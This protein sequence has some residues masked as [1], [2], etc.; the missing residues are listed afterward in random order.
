MK[1][2]R[3]PTEQS[4]SRI[5]NQARDTKDWKAAAEGYRS[6]LSAD[7]S[8]NPIWVQYGNMLKEAGELAR[9]E[10]AYRIALEDAPAIADTYVQL[11]H[12]L[13]LLGRSGEMTHAYLQALSIDPSSGPA[14]EELDRLG[15]RHDSRIPAGTSRLRQRSGVFARRRHGPITL[16]DRAMF[17]QCWEQALIH[18]RAVL[19]RKPGL[20][21]ILV[22]Y[23]HA[24]KELGRLTE[25]ASAYASAAVADTQDPDASL[26]LGHVLLRLDRQQEAETAY[27]A[28]LAIAPSLAGQLHQVG[29]CGT[30]DAKAL[31][32]EPLPVDEQGGRDAGVPDLKAE[33]GEEWSGRFDPDWY[34]AR[35]P[36][37]AA[38]GIDPLD[39]FLKHGKQEGR[40]PNAEKQTEAWLGRFDADWYLTHYS[41]IAAAKIDPL[42]HFL[43]HGWQEGRALNKKEYEEAEAIRFDADWY[44][45]HYTDLA[46]MGID[47]LT[48][49]LCY[50][51]Q[52]GR[53]PNDKRYWES[54]SE[55]L[56]A[57]WY[58]ERNQDVAR[59]Q[60]DAL[61]HYSNFGIHER[62]R[63]NPDSPLQGVPVTDARLECLKAPRLP[64][65]EVALLVSHSPTGR[66]KPHVQH[67][68]KSFK[69]QGVAIILIVMTDKPFIDRNPGLLD[70]VD[71]L[72]VRDNQGY[73]FAAWA[74]ILRICPALFDSSILYLVND[75]VFG[76]TN[77]ATFREMLDRLRDNPAD[78]IGLTEDI[79]KNRH[80]QS[81]FLACKTAVLSNTV[82]REFIYRIVSLQHKN[83]VFNEY[84]TCLT[85]IIR[86]ALLRCDALFPFFNAENPTLHCWKELV[87]QG[88]PFVKVS[89]LHGPSPGVSKS[90]WR[91]I[92]GGRGYDVS[93]ADGTLAE[94]AASTS[95]P[96]RT[97][98][99]AKKNFRQ[100]ALAELHTFL[101]S[102]EVI[103]LPSAN[104]PTVT[105]L[106]V[107]YNE[108]ELTLRC[109]KSIVD[110]VDVPTEVIIVDNASSD[111]TGYLFDRLEGARIFRNLEDL[112]F[113]RAANQGAARARGR[114]LLLINND[115][116][117]T[118]GALQYGLETLDSADDIGAVG[119]KL[120]LPDGTLQEAGSIIWNDA[121]CL[122]YGRGCDPKIAAFQFRRE[123]DYCSG[124]YML[125]RRDV[126]E[127][128]GRFDAVFA[129]A[130]YEET[131]LCMRIRDA[132]YR[133][134][135]D[136]RIE[137]LHY[138]FASAAS[139]TEAS[140]LMTRNR[141]L[142]TRRNAASL[143]KRHLASSA[144]VIVARLADRW[145]PRI[146]MI[147]NMMPFTHLG[148]GFPRAD[149]I[150]RAVVEAGFFVTYYPTHQT[151]ADWAEVHANFPIDV[152]FVLGANRLPLDQFLA[153]RIGYYTAMVVC[154]PNNMEFIARDIIQHPERY[155]ETAIAYDAEALVTPREVMRLILAGTPM[156]DLAKEAALKTE[157][158]LTQ[159][160]D[161]V[162]AVNDQEAEIFRTAGHQ[163]VHV[164]GHA[165]EAQPTEVD[166][167]GRRDFLLVGALHHDVMPNVDALLWF[168]EQ[169]MPKLDQ[170]IGTKYRLYI[171]GTLGAE[172]LK[173]PLPLRV[174]LLG[175][176]D[177]LTDF[178]QRA[179][180]FIA[181]TR[182]AAG[183]PLKI[184]EA[185]SRGLPSV[186][187][188]LL[189]SQLGW[190]AGSEL[191][192]GDTPEAFAAECA[193]LYLDDTL[194]LQVR[195]AS[196]DRVTLD[197]DPSRFARGMVD[198]MRS[199]RVFPVDGRLQGRLPTG[200]L[201]TESSESLVTACGKGIAPVM[202]SPGDG[203]NASIADAHHIPVSEPTSG[204]EWSAVSQ[205]L[206]N[207]SPA[208][209]KSG[210]AIVYLAYGA[211]ESC[212]SAFDCF[213]SS[214]KAFPAG[215]DHSL[216]VAMKCFRSSEELLRAEALFASVGGKA[217]HMDN[218]GLDIGAYILAAR[219]IPE[220]H[221]C[222]LNHFSEIL[223][224]GWLEKMDT[225]LG[226]P[227]VGLVG[228]TGSFECLGHPSIT[229]PQFPNPHLRTNGF[230]IDGE[231][232]LTLMADTPLATK[233]DTYLVESGP[234]SL[235]RKVAARGFDVLIVGRNGRAYSQR[236]WPCSDTFRQGE[237]SNLLIGDNRTR[238]F[239]DAPE[240][241]KLTLLRFA[242][243][244]YLDP[245][246]VLMPSNATARNIAA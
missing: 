36:D 220:K 20:A 185:A 87:S 225:H 238:D 139:S 105:I 6:V 153:D 147:E 44:R 192:T 128:L 209:V 99:D 169:V 204:N 182:Y 190:M 138:E 74:H 53:A 223:A 194:W 75:S 140:S 126:F 58:L 136:P 49:F 227:E 233:E 240:D 5:A 56:D 103:K 81:Y 78:F 29:S 187:T 174:I 114:T 219:E 110:T 181:P 37:I 80:L 144:P 235:T 40:M 134:M 68:I 89:T 3:K 221:I 202:T 10:R 118:P 198:V 107:V 121:A 34:I 210:V 171:A 154:R 196:L 213:I 148:A 214:Y 67:Y 193:R 13:K 102:G 217:I 83:D 84:E 241:L 195:Q 133:I 54:L 237:Q 146:L 158:D 135:Y 111:D 88:F 9:A 189:A 85:D 229:F 7:P 90:G 38:A 86:A 142:F 70:L 116:C 212:F 149:R 175:R 32:T 157:L 132:G 207:P 76:P 179:R 159:M 1:W 206:R 160:A 151:E 23:G 222:F 216:Y 205:P 230:M 200:M 188:S 31:M 55:N 35:Y 108:A 52:E 15:V 137:V 145:R 124:A 239:Q 199:I 106:I 119:A 62:R 43:Q 166:L 14:R 165:I 201:L 191:L 46:S 33:M 71:G 27:L 215:I 117:L 57:T 101:A 170:L 96:V 42:K 41:D 73:D 172:R 120:I 16:G 152:E 11:G 51:K 100:Q 163:N 123:V 21:P 231:L 39:H 69:R 177:N 109:L 243:G 125:L 60:A 22:Q 162:V 26:H 19:D 236:W 28:A 168:V 92:L 141:G 79:Q 18:Y 82:F 155:Q 180:V 72:F 226:R 203:S 66:L 65:R 244:S 112:H 104:A 45:A 61:F 224:E 245:D 178:Y 91:A 176:V 129:P 186:A 98:Q 232:F 161:A 197:C 167:Q 115:A 93:L 48:H 246:D 228:A 8:N 95:F 25:A 97:L 218:Y 164:L 131:D 143:A 234:G 127:F 94:L 59:S 47:P 50:G 113:L 17:L 64:L 173:R 30:A 77:D 183:I 156:T 242:W 2:L 208:I 4:S 184:Y 211:D 150:L 12:V 24:L 130:Y 63:P 122:G